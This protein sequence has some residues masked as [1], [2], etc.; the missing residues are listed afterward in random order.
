MA[1]DA[2]GDKLGQCFMQLPPNFTPERAPQLEEYLLNLPEDI[3]LSIEFRHP[4]WFMNDASAE[5]CWALLKEKGIGAVISATAGRRDAVHMRM[6]SEV[7]VL[8]Y[9]GYDLHSSDRSRIQQWSERI[10]QWMEIGL[11]EVYLLI[12]QSDSIY[13]PETIQLFAEM[14]LKST[15]IRIKVPQIQQGLF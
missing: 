2:F 11:K 9:G 8:R 3:P 4:S 10:A 13:T 1:I 12:H 14:L 15:G 7:L 6:T 5:H